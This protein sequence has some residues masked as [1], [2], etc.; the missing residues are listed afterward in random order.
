MVQ[1]NNE[2]LNKDDFGLIIYKDNIKV[3]VLV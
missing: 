3:Y 2:L 1:I